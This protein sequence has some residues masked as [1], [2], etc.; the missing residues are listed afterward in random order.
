MQ[1]Q[2]R[3]AEMD[4]TP[5][6]FRCL[7]ADVHS[8]LL[9][10]TKRLTLANFLVLGFSGVWRNV[11]YTTALVAQLAKRQQSSVFFASLKRVRSA[12]G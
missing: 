4:V 8:Y 12:S 6:S 9:N 3:T 5:K 11:D 1:L 2:P 10:S 7:Y